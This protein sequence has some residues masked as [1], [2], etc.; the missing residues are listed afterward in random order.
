MESYLLNPG[1]AVDF[2][3]PFDRTVPAEVAL[4]PQAEPSLII[5]GDGGGPPGQYE[6]S[7]PFETAGNGAKNDHVEAPAWWTDFPYSLCRTGTRTRILAVHSIK[8]KGKGQGK[9]L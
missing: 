6:G 5:D 1:V 9:S 4:P 3:R 8:G 2:T 7:E